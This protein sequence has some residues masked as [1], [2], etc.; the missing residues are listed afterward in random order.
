[1]SCCPASGSETGR[2]ARRAAL[3][4][5]LMAAATALPAQ[6]GVR[7]ALAVDA[8][9]RVVA[10]QQADV[11]GTPASVAKLWVAAAALHFLG[12]SF[13]VKT[14]VV[15]FDP[16]VG[17]ALT[18]DLVIRAAGDPTWN[19]RFYPG[20]AQAP[21]DALA[22]SV[23]KAGVRRILGDLV[24]DVGRFPGRGAPATRAI[25]EVPLGYGAPTSALAVDENTVRVEIAPGA[26]AGERARAR[27]LGES[28]E[29]ELTNRMV[30]VGR[31][32]H[33]KGTVEIAPVWGE[34][35][36]ILRGEYPLS[37]P[38]Y[39]MDLALPDPDQAA[40]RAL[41]AALRRAG[42]EIVG[43]V[44][45]RAVGT[46][47]AVLA[48]F[49]GHPLADLIP[50]MLADS[51]NWYAEMLARQLALQ[52][53]GAGR[54]DEALR[55]LERFAEEVV[56]AP[57]GSVRLDDASGLSPFSLMTPRAVVEL[58]RWVR[59]Q[60][61]HTVFEDA[62]AT[63]D[64]G[65]LHSWPALPAGLRAKTGTIQNTLALAGYLP[66]PGR[67]PLV[68]ALF[69]NHRPDDRALLRREIAQELSAWA[70]R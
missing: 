55:R 36:L 18:G 61:W 14:E 48:R 65:T 70:R 23:A 60:P 68:F 59:L 41:H 7:T 16:I 34:R 62:L 50:L 10:E 22:T 9:G 6:Q 63:A 57:K 33:G 42:I 5:A 24:V 58:L 66:R 49:E 2:L 4:L 3:S 26:A 53:Q 45:V 37:E 15:A 47:G 12:P 43:D 51:H 30:T 8:G 38:A 20:R 21:L 69:L 40:G 29:L 67:E 44:E 27:F 64:R 17:G 25:A 31:E 28:F 35:R 32:R 56:G 52:Q 46:G 11:L 39:P 13:R 54:S 19:A 1:M